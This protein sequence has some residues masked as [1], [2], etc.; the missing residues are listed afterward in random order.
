MCTSQLSSTVALDRD[1]LALAVFLARRDVARLCASFHTTD[2]LST[3]PV[4]SHSATST[5]EHAIRAVPRSSKPRSD[6]PVSGGSGRVIAGKEAC[7]TT[8][9]RHSTCTRSRPSENRTTENGL[10]VR[11][12]SP[13]TRDVDSKPAIQRSRPL[14]APTEKQLQSAKDSHLR[15]LQ[16]KIARYTSAITELRIQSCDKPSSNPLTSVRRPAKRTTH[17]HIPLRKHQQQLTS[18]RTSSFLRNRMVP[19]HVK[20]ARPRRSVTSTQP[21]TV[22]PIFTRPTSPAVTFTT[23]LVEQESIR[24]NVNALWLQAVRALRNQ[25]KNV[26]LLEPE[27]NSGFPSSVEPSVDHFVAPTQCCSATEDMRCFDSARSSLEAAMEPA[28]RAYSPLETVNVDPVSCS[29][30]GTNVCALLEELQ[31]AEAEE[32]SIRHR[33]ARLTLKNKADDQILPTTT[34]STFIWEPRSPG[35]SYRSDCAMTDGEKPGQ[36]HAQG[37]TSFPFVFSKSAPPFKSHAHTGSGHREGET[38]P[39][40]VD[41]PLLLRLPTNLHRE[42]L[43]EASRRRDHLEASRKQLNILSTDECKD[44]RIVDVCAKFAD[45]LVDQLLDDIVVEI[46]RETSN[47]VDDIVEGE[48]FTEASDSTLT[49]NKTPS[50]L[51]LTPSDEPAPQLDQPSGDTPANWFIPSSGSITPLQGAVPVP[52]SNCS[53]Q[54]LHTP[55]SSTNRVSSSTTDSTVYSSHF[56]K[57]TS[58]SIRLSPQIQ[59]RSDNSVREQLSLDLISEQASLLSS[60][61]LI[62]NLALQNSTDA[63]DDADSDH[64]IYVQ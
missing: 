24:E 54:S 13:P 10:P 30:S 8:T 59:N 36:S 23:P 4:P 28:L 27:R 7:L 61:T 31:I 50:D 15:Q 40:V 56:E 5:L 41:N 37:I 26:V 1:R 57:T 3:V 62:A 48:L 64:T 55:A 49:M 43:V 34:P 63:T 42:L 47:L 25:D 20:S 52:T 14:Y 11:G 18:R 21:R 16:A 33:W 58:N 46:D 29:M 60:A 22:Q 39:P 6:P 38:N 2:G 17:D 53:K 19:L 9:S 45:E 32:D 12:D 51:D 44:L 35:R